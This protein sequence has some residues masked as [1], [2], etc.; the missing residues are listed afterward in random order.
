MEPYRMRFTCTGGFVVILPLP[1]IELTGVEVHETPKHSGCVWA[2]CS[3]KTTYDKY[4]T[5]LQIP[6]I[7][8]TKEVRR[9]IAEEKL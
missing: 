3:A 4:G 1:S 9:K 5:Y 7:S 8:E 6:S 2:A